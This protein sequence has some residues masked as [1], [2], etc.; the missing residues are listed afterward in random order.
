MSNNELRVFI[1]HHQIPLHLQDLDYKYILYSFKSIL[2][3]HRQ[4][5]ST[6]KADEQIEQEQENVETFWEK[7]VELKCEFEENSDDYG[8]DRCME[9]QLK[10]DLITCFSQREDLF[11]R[12]QGRRHHIYHLTMSSS[13]SSYLSI[14]TVLLL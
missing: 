14:V 2:D 13:S 1:L 3:K 7:L 6:G 12:I 4:H 9:N 8:E 5:A 10:L 11:R